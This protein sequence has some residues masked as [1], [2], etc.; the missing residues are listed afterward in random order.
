[1]LS[2][3]VRTASRYIVGLDVGTTK[4][5]VVVG[6]LIREGI[7]IISISTTPSSGLKKGVV[8]D[9]DST[10]NSIKKAISDAEKQSGIVIGEVYVGIAGSHI[11]SF[12][13]SGSAV[14]RGKEVTNED[15]LRAIESASAVDVPLD[16]EII[17]IIPT[18]FFLD[19]QGGIKDPVGM[20]G[21]K[22]SVNV[23]I[24]TGAVTSIQNLVKCC[25]KAGL[26]VKDIIL[27]SLAS[28][29]ASL[30]P[31]EREAGIALIDIGGGTTDIAIF[32]DNWLRH[33]AVY[34]I[35]GNHFTNDLSIGL[36][37][38]FQEAEKIKIS[39]GYILPALGREDMEV[40]II[41]IDG[42][43]R[44]IP[45]KYISEILLPRS[46]ELLELIKN[47]IE[48]V[49]K[50]GISI[51]GAVLTGGASLLYDFDRLAETILSLPVR[52]GYPKS[53]VR[54]FK[55]QSLK[56]SKGGSYFLN[57][58]KEDFNNPM[59]TTGIGLVIY[60]AASSIEGGLIEQDSFTEIVNKIAL[61]FKNIFK[62]IGGQSV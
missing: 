5:C 52:I 44:K 8:V 27:Q 35:G 7:S 10:V 56:F 36:K 46:E 51:C 47:E 20:S 39:N 4:I 28:A 23:F 17:Q 9:I 29:D 61:W 26:E 60:G 58:L 42:H 3:R 43:S 22:L 37:L 57:E 45:Q 54:P 33:A 6:E 2:R 62:K 12:V 16:R 25:Q 59:Y 18:N 21:Y 30:T 49:N 53:V 24:I 55:L 50:G 40:E 14:V 34:G 11:K 41:P 38:P 31:Q 1:M 15:V 32:K 19:G 13:S 48:I